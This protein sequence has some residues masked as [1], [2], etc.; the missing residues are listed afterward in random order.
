MC[1]GW[2]NIPTFKRWGDTDEK[3]A[4]RELVDQ[5]ENDR[6]SIG[7]Y[8]SPYTNKDVD[9]LIGEETY[10]IEHVVPRSVINSKNPGRA[11]DDFYGW[12][13]ADRHANSD[14]S[15]LP[16]VLWPLEHVSDR[17]RVWISGELHYN[18]LEEHKARL[19][20]RWIYIRCTY[21]LEDDI[22]PPSKAQ[23]KHIKDIVKIAKTQNLTQ[24][25]AEERLH[26]LLSKRC[27]E[28]YGVNWKN[29]LNTDKADTLLDDKT[30]PNVL[31][32]AYT[33]ANQL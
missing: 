16:L 12:D 31:V 5:S 23:Q 28:E 26:L 11:E 25:Y 15:N 21:F 18:P 10:S 33:V 14:R 32:P 30:L 20:R 3:R 13:L 19:A 8:N 4:F 9:V 29:P 7:Q 17:G 24:R 2:E 1:G 27:H 22:D 6:F